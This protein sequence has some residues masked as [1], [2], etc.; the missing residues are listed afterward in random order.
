MPLCQ[1]AT[2]TAISPP[3]VAATSVNAVSCHIAIATRGRSGAH[4]ARRRYGVD[5]A[6]SHAPVVFSAKGATL[7]D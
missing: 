4:R 2:P 6:E 5:F 1:G 3:V 7:E